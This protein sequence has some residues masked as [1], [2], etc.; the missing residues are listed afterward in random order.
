MKKKRIIALLLVLVVVGISV[1]FAT[2]VLPAWRGSSSP[3]LIEELNDPATAE[4]G[5]KGHCDLR[6]RNLST[7][8]LSLRLERTDCECAHVEVCVTPDEWKGLDSQSFLERATEPTLPWQKLEQGGQPFSVPPRSHGMIRVTWRAFRLGKSAIGIDL[9]VNDG[10]KEVSQKVQTPVNFVEPVLIC[11]EDDPK[12]T[13]IDVGRL[14]A[15]EERTANF[16]CYSTTRDE[17]ALTPAPPSKDSCVLYGTP[18]PLTSEELQALAQKS[19][20]AQVRAGFR[21]K[22]TVREQADG[23]RL[24]IGPFHRRIVYKTDVY[25]EHQVTAFVNGTVEGEVMLMDSEGNDYLDFGMIIPNDPKL[26]TFTLE[27]GDAQLQL[28]V[29]EEQTIP[30]L[31]IEMLDGKTGKP[32]E[33]GKRWRVRAVFRTDALFRGEFPNPT[34]PGY[35]SA[36]LCSIVFLVSRPG[37][38]AS[39]QRRLFIPVR[40]N[41]R[42]Y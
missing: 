3:L 9:R 14:K 17:F 23:H 11:S 5:V 22:V 15:G 8:P 21:V 31:K 26:V 25:S 29:D 41:V 30:F 10:E 4:S 16:V 37:K 33:K 1:G 7:K 6:F 34:R 13:E 36:D 2:G 18:Q 38:A 28:S 42:I 35:D 39:L 40:G 24:D 27:S 12:A 20:A 19:G 32:V